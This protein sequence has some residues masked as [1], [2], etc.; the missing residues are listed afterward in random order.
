MNPIFNLDYAT[1]RKMMPYLAGVSIVSEF[2]FHFV[3]R[4]YGY[5]GSL[6]FRLF[7]MAISVPVFFIHRLQRLAW[8]HLAYW[9]ASVLLILPFMSTYFAL[10]NGINHY[11]LSSWLLLAMALGLATKIFLLPIHF[12]VGCGLATWLYH[13]QFGLSPELAKASIQMHSSAFLAAMIGSAVK[14]SLEISDRKTQR[15]IRAEALAEEARRNEAAIQKAYDELQKREKCIVRF[16][17]PSLLEEIRNGQDPTDFQPVFRKLAILFCDIR[18]F[19]HLTEI[20]TPLEKQHFLN[21]YLTM[22]TYPIV[23]NGGEVDKIMGDCVMGLFP[24]GDSAVR[25]AVD[26]RLQLQAFNSK[27]YAKG[28]PKIRNG[29]GIAKG[30]VMLGNFGCFQKL[31]RTVIG[32]AVNIA[33]RLE[34]KTKMYNLEVVVTEE[35]IQDLRPGTQHYRWIDTVQVKGSSRHLKL[36]EIYGHQPEEVRA[37]KDKTRELLEKA[38]TIYFQKGF[39]DAQRIFKS[40]LE[41]VPPH[42]HLPH[43]LMDN[44]LNYYLAHCHA[45]INDSNGSW[46]AIT[47]WDGVHV[48]HEK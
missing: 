33:S 24:D 11:W 4:S 47:K 19:T 40:M 37:Y 9:E 38:L 30:E 12:L 27:M 46:E 5:W 26:M 15:I 8:Y 1:T 34:S 20:L 7:L 23:E 13:I 16:I 36:F 18:D 29:I 42:R 25:A 3:D 45:W 28:K 17:R 35:V 2:V 32:E 22:M 10:R 41:Q 44:L 48:F 39:R 14:T 31:D 6:P 21:K 43:D